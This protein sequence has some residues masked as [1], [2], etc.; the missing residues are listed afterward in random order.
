MGSPLGPLMAK[1]FMCG[2]EEQLETQNKVPSFFLLR[3]MQL[4]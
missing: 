2:I 1:T 3:H 4:A